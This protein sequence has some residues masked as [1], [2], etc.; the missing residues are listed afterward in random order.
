MK[1]ENSQKLSQNNEFTENIQK[2]VD[3]IKQKYD[4]IR[5]DKEYVFLFR[6]FQNFLGNKSRIFGKKSSQ[7]RD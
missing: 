3:K 4:E 5:I 1:K 7:K 2:S 6:I